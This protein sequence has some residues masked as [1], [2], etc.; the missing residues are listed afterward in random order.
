MNLAAFFAMLGRDGRVARRNFLPLL[1]QNLVQ[2]MLFVFVFGRVMTTSGMMPEAYKSL[3]LPGIIAIS[4]LLSGL[5]AV[6]FPMIADFQFTREIEDRLLAPMSIEWVAIEKVVAGAIQALVAGSVVIP[7][8]MLVLG[9]GVEISFAQPVELVALALMVATLAAAIGLTLG[10]W[11]G[12]QQIGIMFS[13][14]VGPMIFFGC[15]YYPWSALASFPVLQKLVLLNPFVYASEGFRSALVPQFQHL[16]GYV[17]FGGL[18][19]FNALFVW[20]GLRQFRKKA[21]G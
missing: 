4:M 8:S 6:A 9:S 19:V 3:L 1:L 17:V 13:L 10:C 20:L 14:I 12:Q 5:Q 18:I 21:I 7:T 11:L 16:S 2:P 15:T